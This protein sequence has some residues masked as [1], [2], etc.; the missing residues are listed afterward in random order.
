MAYIHNLVA[1]TLVIIFVAFACT[2]VTAANLSGAICARAPH[3][4]K[5]MEALRSDPRSKTASLVGL[6][7]I[8]IEASTKQAK[9][10]RGLVQTLLRSA[11]NP[12]LRSRYSS[13]LENYED[14]I[15]ALGRCLEFLKN[16]EYAS[17]DSYA[18][19]ALD[20]PVTCDDDFEEPPVESGK[21]KAA[22]A[23]LQDFCDVILIVSSKLSGRKVE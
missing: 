21:L 10:T 9:V 3:P 8:A 16:K 5:C 23:K 2:N 15:D 11:K 18:S 6:A 1:S 17:L 12:R 7:V 14:S 4:P 22:S 19:A 20:S 13:C